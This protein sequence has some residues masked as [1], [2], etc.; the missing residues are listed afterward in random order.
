[1]WSRLKR[2]ECLEFGLT[3][4]LQQM[5]EIERERKWKSESAYFVGFF[6]VSLYST[7]TMAFLCSM[8]FRFR[9]L[10]KKCRQRFIIETHTLVQLAI[11]Y[12]SV[13]TLMVID[14]KCNMRFDWKAH[15]LSAAC[16]CGYNRWT[17]FAAFQLQL[18]FSFIYFFHSGIR[19][20]EHTIAEGEKK[21]LWRRW[22]NDEEIG[23][24]QHETEIVFEQ[25]TK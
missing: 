24:S 20:R 3:P 10:Q 1:M 13:W 4:E 25:K 19:F 23:N 18:F 9:I 6:F 8:V 7:I 5:Q 17:Y 22:Q 16:V 14:L 2:G 21:K 11:L 15:T 12:D